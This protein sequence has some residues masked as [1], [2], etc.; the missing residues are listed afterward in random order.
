MLAI[1]EGR[2]PNGCTLCS[3]V[4]E[5]DLST[6]TQLRDSLAHPATSPSW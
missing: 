6:V 1:E 3:V 4:G 2:E 5:L